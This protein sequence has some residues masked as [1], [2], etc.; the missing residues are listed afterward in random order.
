MN[1]SIK[2]DDLSRLELQALRDQINEKIDHLIIQEKTNLPL[3]SIQDVYLEPCQS[4]IKIYKISNYD[5][6]KEIYYTD[7]FAVSGFG[8][9]Y[10]P[11]NCISAEIIGRRI[12]N[13]TWIKVDSEIFDEAILKQEQM[14]NETAKIEIRYGINFMEYLYSQVD[15]IEP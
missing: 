10:K 14:Q 9:Y 1:E 4:R 6:S 2:L 15:G 3:P 12:K 11:N 7:S 13:G 5:K 8:I